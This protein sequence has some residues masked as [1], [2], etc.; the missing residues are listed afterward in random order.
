MS[1][2]ANPITHPPILR[3][4]TS[5]PFSECRGERTPNDPHYRVHFWQGSKVG[6]KIVLLPFD[7]EGKLVPDDGK[8]APYTGTNVEGK[9]VEHMPLYNADMRTLLDTKMKR[10]KSAVAEPAPVEDEITDLESAAK[11]AADDVNFASW[12]RGEVK[13]QV[14]VLFAAAKTRYH[15]NYSKI[16]EL[17]TDLVLD[18]KVVPEDDVSVELKKHLPKQAA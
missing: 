9:P 18:E 8:T 13:Y 12:L 1:D 7:A 15:K 11:T 16:S 10:L 14:H 17:V 5:R 6:T 4:D 3:L 2:Q